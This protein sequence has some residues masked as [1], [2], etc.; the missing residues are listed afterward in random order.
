MTRFSINFDYRCPFARNA[1]EHVVAALR[2]GA[3]FDVE[4]RAFSLTAAH[5]EEGDPPVFADPAHRSALLAL[6]AGVVVRDRF[7]ERF[8]DAHLSLF[9]VRH[10]DADD[11]REEKVVH[12]ALERAGVDA[13]AV[14]TEIAD[15]WPFAVI[16]DEHTHDVDAYGTF[17]VPTFVVKNSAV[18]V[19]LMTRPKGDGARSQA[20]IERIVHMVSDESEINEFKH[21]RVGR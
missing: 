19:R 11:L 20:L 4:F 18:F 9:A 12:R 15:G 5:A 13:D 21:T 7:P 6:A 8:A 3:P 1:N 16:G 2:S 14:F 10:D 17:G